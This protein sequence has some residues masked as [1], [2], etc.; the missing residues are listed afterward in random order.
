[1]TIFPELHISPQ[2]PPVMIMT[3]DMI[4]AACDSADIH[5]RIKQH[6]KNPR[7]GTTGLDP[8]RSD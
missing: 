2:K 6:Q 8:I 5:Q 3:E 1:M 7:C 4:R